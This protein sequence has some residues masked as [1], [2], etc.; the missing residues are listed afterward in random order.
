MRCSTLSLLLGIWAVLIMLYYFTLHFFP[1]SSEVGEAKYWITVL[2]WYFYFWNTCSPSLSASAH[3][4]YANSSADC[5]ACPSDRQLFAVCFSVC[6]RTS[7]LLSPSSQIPS[8]LRFCLKTIP[9][10][11]VGEMLI[12]EAWPAICGAIR[13]AGAA[14]VQFFLADGRRGNYEWGSLPQPWLLFPTAMYICPLSLSC[15]TPASQLDTLMH[16][17]KFMVQGFLCSFCYMLHTR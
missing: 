14:A 10:V 7:L 16:S 8:W 6:D 13:T 3:W 5:A 15:T 11:S 12:W 9:W 17:P 2:L 4:P 1:F